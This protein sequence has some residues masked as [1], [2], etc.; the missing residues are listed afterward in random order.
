MNVDL[1]GRLYAFAVTLADHYDA[2][3]SNLK[4]AQHYQMAERARQLR[5]EVLNEGFTCLT[6]TDNAQTA[7][8]GDVADTSASSKLVGRIAGCG[9]QIAA[10]GQPVSG[11]ECQLPLVVCLPAL[12]V[13]L[14]PGI[15]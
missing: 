12:S 5:A 1:I 10:Q 15:V 6:T 13:A 11:Q 14:V 2:P 4:T 8:R 7:Q 3:P 9:C